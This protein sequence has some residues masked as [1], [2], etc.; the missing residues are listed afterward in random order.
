M[1]VNRHLI[2]IVEDNPDLR[3]LVRTTFETDCQTAYEIVEAENGAEALQAVEERKPDLIVLDVMMPG[4]MD[5]LEVCMRIKSRPE[6][7]DIRIVML[8]ARG[9]RV[10][11]AKGMEA[12]ADAYLVKPFSPLSL[13]ETAEKLLAGKKKELI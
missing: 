2:L 8:T 5:G 1:R 9:Q 12:G 10:D 4:E 13:L 6:W 3:L 11:I 7:R